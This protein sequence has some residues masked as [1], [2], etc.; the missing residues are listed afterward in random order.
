[1]ENINIPVLSVR[2]LCK[3]YGDG[4]SRVVALDDVSFDIQP[5]R[6]IVVLGQSGSGKST[7]L[8]M[9]GGMDRFD[10]GDVKYKNISLS[11]MNDRLLTDYRRNAVGFVFQSFN[12]IAG[13]TAKENVKLTA[14]K[15]D[16]D[17]AMKA[18]ELVDLKDKADKYPSQLSG[19]QQQRVSIARALAKEPELF[20][21]DEPT[22]ALDT[23]T[24]KTVLLTLEK[25]VRE[26]GKTM[27]IVTH[28]TEI[29]KIAD[30]IIRM[31]NGKIISDELNTEISSVND[32]IW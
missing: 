26:Y 25:L 6:L 13:L 7:L 22:G 28:N 2:N 14:K 27:I 15:N 21:C 17:T 29:A 16:P 12:L 19:G 11:E 30:R 31:K 9:L 32:I 1:M 10:S 18:L 8:N 23:Q 24:G 3:Y 20:L 4:D 5:S